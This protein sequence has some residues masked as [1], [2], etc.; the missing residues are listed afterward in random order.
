M[1]R[2]IWLAAPVLLGTLACTETPKQAAKKKEPEKPPEPVTGRYA[3]H[4]MFA[5]ARAW[6]ADIQPLQLASIPLTDVKPDGGKHGAWQCMFASPG[7]GKMKTFTYSVIEAGG[8]LHKG[9][10][11]SLEESFTGSRGQARPFLVAAL[12]IDTDDA[13]ATAMKKSAEYV[14][15]NPNM[16]VSFLA[17]YTPRFPN[18]TWRV[19]WGESVSQSP[20]SVFVDAT[21]G[22]FLTAV[23]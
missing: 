3:F 22:E 15:K 16:P 11:S 4:Q 6:S 17:E 2:R 23:R 21:T 13:Y 18:L 9:V 5:A 14:K 1:T 8:N 7:K 12:R 20:Y 10:F 19:F